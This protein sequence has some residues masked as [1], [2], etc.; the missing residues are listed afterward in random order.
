MKV[1]IEWKYPYKKKEKKSFIS[2]WMDQTEALQIAQQL[3]K[4]SPQS[5]CI[6][7]EETG[8]TWTKK[9]F[10]KLLEKSVG[11]PSQLTLFFDGNYHRHSQTAG[12]GVVLYYQQDSKSIRQRWNERLEGL[13]NNN[14]AEY[15]A[16]YFGLQKVEELGITGEKLTIKGDSHGVLM[17]LKGEWPC[18]EEDLNRWLDKIEEKISQLK[19]YPE[20][21]PIMRNEN[22]EADQLASQALAGIKIESKRDDG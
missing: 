9:E 16:L 1:Q 19:L 8:I 14:E 21:I 12:I 3:E 5:E 6:F 10:K 17:Q 4:M 11:K 22:K 13:I 18:F 7:H 20:Y 15:A 2:E